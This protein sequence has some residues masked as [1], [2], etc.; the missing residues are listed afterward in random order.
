[1]KVS[2]RETFLPLM[3]LLDSLHGHVSNHVA[4]NLLTGTLKIPQE[5]HKESDPSADEPEP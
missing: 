5:S 3:Y 4:F 1:M 2:A